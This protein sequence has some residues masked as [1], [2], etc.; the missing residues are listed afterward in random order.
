MFKKHAT[1]DVLEAFSRAD[2]KF[3]EMEEDLFEIPEK[4]GM[5]YAR[6]RAIASKIN[7][8]F[9]GFEREELKKAYKS[10]IGKPIFV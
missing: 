1:C 2:V 5:V 8:N 6:V 7:N 4:D 3:K 10:F 9:D